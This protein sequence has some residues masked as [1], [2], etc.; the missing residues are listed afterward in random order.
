MEETN[1]QVFS[2]VNAQALFNVLN[3]CAGRHKQYFFKAARL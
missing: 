2:S 1:D 3:E